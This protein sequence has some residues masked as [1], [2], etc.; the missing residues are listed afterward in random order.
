LLII[1]KCNAKPSSAC[2]APVILDPAE[3]FSVNSFAKAARIEVIG[4][5]SLVEFDR[6]NNKPT[7]LM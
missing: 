4:A 3:W 1:G 6:Q 7:F 2:A 5:L